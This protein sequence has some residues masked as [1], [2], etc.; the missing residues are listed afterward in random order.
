MGSM[1]A[2][3]A[4]VIP[5]A[6]PPALLNSVQAAAAAYLS[7]ADEA[8]PDMDCS[9]FC[10]THWMPLGSDGLRP[11]LPPRHPIEEAIWHLSSLASVRG[12]VQQGAGTPEYVGAEWWLQEQS[13]GDRPKELH[14]DKDAWM[15][16]GEVH[17]AHPLWSSVLYLSA[18]GG[19][20][21][22]FGQRK[23]GGE[24]V[25]KLPYEVFVAFPQPAQYL[26]FPGDLLHGV[27]EPPPPPAGIAPTDAMPRVT[28]LVNW[29]SLR[30]AVAHDHLPPHL[31][32]ALAELGM[33][34]HTDVIGEQACAPSDAVVAPRVVIPNQPFMDGAPHWRRQL[35]PLP[36][37][38]LLSGYC[39]PLLPLL[40]RYSDTSTRREDKTHP[41]WHWTDEDEDEE[42]P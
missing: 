3:N 17:S 21:A 39:A 13:P 32:A 24:L 12:V 26:L 8:P 15:E 40:L 4:T 38:A 5:N 36:V 42:C 18:T 33:Y 6:L 30:P 28:L 2:G 14:T 34:E 22:I 23:V 35:L 10:N 29:W 9:C 1:A 25:P 31:G 7:A 27:L 41:G 37:V 20:T 19:P 16:G 11:L